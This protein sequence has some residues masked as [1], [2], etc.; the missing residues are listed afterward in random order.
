MTHLFSIDALTI[1][2]SKQLNLPLTLTIDGDSCQQTLS[3]LWQLLASLR[4]TLTNTDI[5]HGKLLL[6]DFNENI[7]AESGLFIFKPGDAK[8]IKLEA[9]IQVELVFD[10]Q[11]PLNERLAA[12]AMTLDVLR[13]LSTRYN[14]PEFAVALAFAS[15][16]G[17][18]L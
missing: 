10:F 3:T 1:V 8:P 15:P 2:S 17:N 6:T 7:S 4:Q 11:S 18:Q 14:T 12:L 13:N 9:I 5:G 16:Q